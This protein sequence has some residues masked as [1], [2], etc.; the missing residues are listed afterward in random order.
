MAMLM[1]WP[2]VASGFLA[3]DLF[4]DLF[5]SNSRLRTHNQNITVAASMMVERKTVG[6]LS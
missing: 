3:S 6:L 1:N 5:N 4:S 2:L